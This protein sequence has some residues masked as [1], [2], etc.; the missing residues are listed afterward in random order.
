MGT[1]ALKKAVLTENFFINVFFIFRPVIGYG[2]NACN[3]PHLSS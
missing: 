1:D 2:G 3:F